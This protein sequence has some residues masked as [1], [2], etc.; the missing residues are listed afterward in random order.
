[1]LKNLPPGWMTVD[2]ETVFQ[3]R[4]LFY[5]SKKGS[6]ST[7]IISIDNAAQDIH[8]KTDMAPT[9]ILKKANDSCGEILDIVK[10][11]SN[12]TGKENEGVTY[13]LNRKAISELMDLSYKQNEETVHYTS[14]IPKTA[15]AGADIYLPMQKVIDIL[16][17]TTY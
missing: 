9:E 16:S 1:M 11:Y 3:T 13:Y 7:S 12:K 4:N 14:I 6:A 2:N 8:I 10:I 15:N 5:V 17:T